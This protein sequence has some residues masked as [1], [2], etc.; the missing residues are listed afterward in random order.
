MANNQIETLHAALSIAE[1][2][3]EHM[4]GLKAAR[5]LVR[6]KLFKTRDHAV[7]LS[8]QLKAVKEQNAALLLAFNQSDTPE[9]GSPH[10]SAT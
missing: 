10:T 6:K 9:S 1:M 3:I 7:R 2:K 4:R 8:G 5:N